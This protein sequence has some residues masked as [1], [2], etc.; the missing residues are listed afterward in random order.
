[1][2]EPNAI[3]ASPKHSAKRSLGRLQRLHVLDLIGADGFF[4]GGGLTR[5]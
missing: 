3:K 4:V 2:A 5:G 1:M